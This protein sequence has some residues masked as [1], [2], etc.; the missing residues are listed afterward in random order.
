MGNVTISLEDKD[1]KKLRRFAR[2]MFKGKRGSMAKV[3]SSGLEKLELDFERDFAKQRI[4]ARIKTG[5]SMGKVLVK[6][7]S[8][9]YEQ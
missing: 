8:E 9:L 7:R 5:L 2:A 6:H 3:V 4:A 1:E